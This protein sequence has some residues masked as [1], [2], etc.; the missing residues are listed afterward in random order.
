MNWTYSLERLPSRNNR[1]RHTVQVSS[2]ARDSME[3]I[4]IKFW[5]NLGTYAVD[6]TVKKPII[7]FVEVKLGHAPVVDASVIA[8]F[9]SIN[10]KAMSCP[11]SASLCMTAATVTQT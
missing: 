11:A 3:Q 9:H 5:T 10:Q 6:V 4:S 2:Q 8:Q 1:N 7:I